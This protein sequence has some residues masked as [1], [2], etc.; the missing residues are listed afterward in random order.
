[1]AFIN[2]VFSGIYELRFARQG[3]NTEFRTYKIASPPVD[4]V[5]GTFMHCL[6]LL[7]AEIRPGPIICNDKRKPAAGG[8]WQAGQASR[9]I[10]ED[11]PSLAHRGWHGRRPQIGYSPTIQGSQFDSGRSSSW[12]VTVA[13]RSR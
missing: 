3:P 2:A 4:A 7:A 9:R 13:A 12:L 11:D 6:D 8:S 5:T 10:R 1:M